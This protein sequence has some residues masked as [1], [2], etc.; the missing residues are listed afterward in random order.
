M[1]RLEAEGGWIPEGTKVTERQ[2]IVQMGAMV[3][4]VLKLLKMKI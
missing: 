1:R 2:Q 3:D 4:E